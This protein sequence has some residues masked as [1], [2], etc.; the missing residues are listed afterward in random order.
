M[1]AEDKAVV[2][3]FLVTLLVHTFPILYNLSLYP[4]PYMKRRSTISEIAL[5]K[6]PNLFLVLAYMAEQPFPFVVDVALKLDI[7]LLGI[8]HFW[9]PVDAS[10]VRPTSFAFRYN[11]F[12]VGAK[13]AS[14][15]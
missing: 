3:L 11:T 7:V 15:L 5:Q 8:P 9:H 2:R 4:T 10:V 1:V 13:L 12:Y 14:D 6:I